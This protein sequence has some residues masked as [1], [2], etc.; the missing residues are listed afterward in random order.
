MTSIFRQLSLP[1]LTSLANAIADKRLVLPLTNMALIGY[2]P[3]TLANAITS[4]V[5]QL[6]ISG[7]TSSQIAYTLRLLAEERAE[8]QKLRDRVDLVWTGQ[9]FVGS[10]SRDTHIVVQEL[11]AAARNSV[12][13][14]SYALDKSASTRTLFKILAQQMSIFP[15]L[16]VQIFVNVH[17]LHQD[18]TPDSV[19]LRQFADSFRKEIWTSNKL[20]DLFHDP[21]SLSMEINKKACLHAKCVVVDQEKVLVTSANFTEA[22]HERNIE[23]GIFVTDTA[24]ANAI[25]SQFDA[26]TRRGILCQIA[27]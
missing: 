25:T 2:V 12:L 4:E 27:L 13:I 5:N 22:A 23:A 9:E 10:T 3:D 21:R 8:S 11:F 19:L 20:P 7:F 16:K 24:I 18:K 1:N 15:E 14:S 6:L 26:L 17:R